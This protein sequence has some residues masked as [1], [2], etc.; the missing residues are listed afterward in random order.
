MTLS[1]ALKL[2][3]RGEAIYVGKQRALARRLA[4]RKRR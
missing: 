3:L 1:R 4:A 2:H